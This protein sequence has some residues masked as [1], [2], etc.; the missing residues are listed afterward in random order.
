MRDNRGNL[1]IEFAILFPLFLLL[2]IGMFDIGMLIIE[3]M[4][5]E[6]ATESAAKCFAT[7][8]NP[9]NPNPNPICATPTATAVYAAGLL[10]AVLG[11]SASNFS[12]VLDPTCGGSV[13]VNYTYVPMILPSNIPLRTSACYFAG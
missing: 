13:T 5:V 7:N 3:R 10:P 11:I 9:P 2:A 4:Q 8:Q 1:S 6:F 12:A